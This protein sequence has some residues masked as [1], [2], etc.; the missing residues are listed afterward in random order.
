MFE[1]ADR[2]M[3]TYIEASDEFGKSAN[4]FLQHIHL[5]PQAM[6]AFRQAMSA[7]AELRKTLDNRDETLRVL[8]TQL[9]Q[10]VSSPFGRPA[11]AE[12]K[13]EPLKTSSAAAGGISVVKTF[14]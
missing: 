10:A 4:E 13:L 3:A 2:L 14:P 7:S 1:N 8:M 9:E 12:K 11:A 5:L 6:N